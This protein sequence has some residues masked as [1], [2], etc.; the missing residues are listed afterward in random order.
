V[1]TN[2]RNR[3]RNLFRST[4]DCLYF[5]T[6]TPTRACANGETA[7]RTSRCPVFIRFP[8]RFTNSISGARDNRCAREKVLRACVLRRQPDCQLLP[9][10]LAAACQYLTPPSRRHPLAKS[11]R[12][13]AALIPRPICGIAHNSP[14]DP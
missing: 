3:R 10:L 9:S 12:P 11:V 7:I 13:N 14:S 2:S 4:T 6:T 1:R 8:V 5:G